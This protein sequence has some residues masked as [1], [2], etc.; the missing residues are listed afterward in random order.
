MFDL[1]IMLIVPFFTSCNRIWVDSP[2]PPAPSEA[3]LQGKDES[4]FG[5]THAPHAL[6]FCCRASLASLST[7]MASTITS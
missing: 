4:V 6:A 2:P 5:E 1:N 3:T 7:Y